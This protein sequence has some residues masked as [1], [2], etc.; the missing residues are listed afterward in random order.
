M[1]NRVIGDYG[2]PDDGYQNGEA[3]ESAS[4]EMDA[5][6]MNNLV[7]DTASMSRTSK[8]I[9]FQFKTTSTA[10]PVALVADA[11][12]MIDTHWGT[13][14]GSSSS[15]YPTVANKE[16]AGQYYFEWEDDLPNELSDD[17]PLEIRFASPGNVN[18]S[19]VFRRVQVQVVNA[20]AVRVNILT[21]SPEA[22]SEP[23]NGTKIQIELR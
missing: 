9:F 15:L 3:V 10:A 19:T 22:L 20:R 17:E 18:S 7:E 14:T 23:A 2:A 21:G 4:D 6:Y 13:A 12:W 1:Q 11:D 16:A 8:K 5:A